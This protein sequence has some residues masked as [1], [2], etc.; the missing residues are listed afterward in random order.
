MSSIQGLSAATS[1]TSALTASKPAAKPGGSEVGE[2]A[3]QERQE[4]LSGA[5]EVGE[6]PRTNPG[7]RF[8]ALA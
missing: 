1:F 5:P 8:S 7:S 4:A 2:T 6:A 3:Q